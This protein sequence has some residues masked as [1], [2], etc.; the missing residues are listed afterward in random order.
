MRSGCAADAQRARSVTT[1]V[2][3]AKKDRCAYDAA[4]K[5]PQDSPFHLLH[6]NWGEIEEFAPIK[7]HTDGPIVPST[8]ST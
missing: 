4:P 2:V 5:F 8:I 6:G 7:I 3:E 1:A